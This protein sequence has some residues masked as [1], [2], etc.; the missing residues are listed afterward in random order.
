MTSTHP[1]DHYDLSDVLAEE[2]KMLRQ[3]APASARTVL[4]VIALATV[5]LLMQQLWVEAAVWWGLTSGMAG[6]T[7]LYARVYWRDG[8]PDGQTRH[9]LHGHVAL[10]ALTGMV[11]CGLAI[12][13]SDP[14]RELQTIVAGLFLTSITT[15]G[16]MAG[17][18]YRPGYVALAICALLPFSVYLLVVMTGVLQFY[19]MFML[20]YFAFCYVTNEQASRRTQDAIAAGL[21]RDAMVEIFRQQEEIAQLHAERHRLHAAIQHDMSQPLLAQ[22]HFVDALNKLLDDPEQRQLIERIQATQS[23]QE[24]LLA[25]LSEES[26][27]DFVKGGTQSAAIALSEIFAHLSAEFAVTIRQVGS[28]LHTEAAVDTLVS[29]QFLVE[30]ILRN[31]LT[32]AFKY[33]TGGGQVWLSATPEGDQVRISVRDN[34]PGIPQEDQQ[35]IF[36]E[37]VRLPRDLAQPGTGL[38]LSI[39]QQLATELGGSLELTSAEGKGTT[40]SLLLP[41]I[42]DASDPSLI[43]KSLFLLVVGHET[44]P[45]LGD[46]VD[47]VSGWL[48]EFAHAPSPAEATRLIHALQLKPDVILYDPLSEGAAPQ[49]AELAE[50]APVLC[51]QRHAFELEPLANVRRIQ[52][53]FALKPLRQAIS[54]AAYIKASE[55]AR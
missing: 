11:W 32:N 38:G 54:D 41:R 28:T 21:G 25:A 44:S 14:Q 19:G 36:D 10:T 46:W 12:Y 1:G 4:L 27:H 53:P 16:A 39:C 9:Y 8:I 23:S 24:T 31:L 55:R 43:E 20:A 2:A 34:G 52:A 47:L 6:I 50:I 37:Y 26:G 22:R 3:R 15:G 29:N 18:I 7:V 40:V 30:R 33:Q 13:L 5:M 17:T 35:R 45:T 42:T 51:I 49:V 48:W